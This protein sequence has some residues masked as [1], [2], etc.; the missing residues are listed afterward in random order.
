MKNKRGSLEA[1]ILMIVA[2]AAFA[3]FLL[4]VGYIGSRIGT[5]LQSQFNTA[6]P[7]VNESIQKTIDVSE[8]MLGPLWFLIFAGLLL[9]VFISAW[10][11]RMHPM[12]IPV[13]IIL[14][15]VAIIVGIA[16]SNAYH[17]LAITTTLDTA[18]S[19]QGAVKFMMDKLPYI[20][21]IV[22]LISIL[23]MFVRPKEEQ[24]AVM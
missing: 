18:S 3:I 21:L 5:E 7:E 4:I 19:Q 23:I 24:T 17:E 1:G 15:I 20:A 10:Q 16:M 12:L 6:I 22:G 14:L 8:T 2:I 11:M 9:G 13:F